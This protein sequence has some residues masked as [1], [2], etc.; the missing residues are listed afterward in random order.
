M[1]VVV[2]AD[3]RFHAWYL[4]IVKINL[5]YQGMRLKNPDKPIGCRLIVARLE[6]FHW[7][8]TSIDSQGADIHLETVQMAF[9]RIKVASTCQTDVSDAKLPM[10]ACLPFP[11]YE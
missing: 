2:V 5:L 11:F 6:I 3:Q 1:E 8:M 4:Q 7:Y 10:V 9:M